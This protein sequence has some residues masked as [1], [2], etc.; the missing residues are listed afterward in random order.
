MDDFDRCDS[1]EILVQLF[2]TRSNFCVLKK[3]HK[4]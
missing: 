1:G 2:V 3:S 4:I